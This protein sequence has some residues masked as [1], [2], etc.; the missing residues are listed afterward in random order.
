MGPCWISQWGLKR[1]QR[2]SKLSHCSL[3]K[4]FSIQRVWSY[5]M[6]LIFLLSGRCL[7]KKP[8]CCPLSAQGCQI[9]FSLSAHTQLPTTALPPNQPEQ[10][11]KSSGI[12]NLRKPSVTHLDH[13]GLS[14][15]IINCQGHIL[16]GEKLQAGLGEGWS[17]MKG[18]EQ[19]GLQKP[20]GN[21]FWGWKQKV[22]HC[23]FSP[24]SW[25]PKSTW[26]CKEKVKSGWSLK[27]PSQ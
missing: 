12:K 26:E 7:C 22:R 25:L 3:C 1:P 15:T 24:T 17:L 20:R 5:Q 8:W 6:G 27:R 23:L 13:F 10:H 19:R 16:E 11:R 18:S 21:V 9:P 4:I 14:T 2:W